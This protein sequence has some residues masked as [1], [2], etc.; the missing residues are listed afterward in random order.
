[1]KVNVKNCS[2]VFQSEDCN[3][4]KRLFE[5]LF[6]SWT[7]YLVEEGHNFILMRVQQFCRRKIEVL[8]FDHRLGSFVD[9]MLMKNARQPTT[10][11]HTYAMS[12]L[13]IS[14]SNGEKSNDH[15]HFML[16]SIAAHAEYL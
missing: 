1:M 14:T 15:P 2:S 16:N 9:V 7:N 10:L 8:C 6:P 5:A 13:F 11:F 3:R 4:S 12:C